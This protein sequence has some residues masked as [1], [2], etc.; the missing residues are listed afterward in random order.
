LL[1]LAADFETADALPYGETVSFG[2]RK[3]A[4]VVVYGQGTALNSSEGVPGES[5]FFCLGHC[6]R[7]RTQ[8]QGAEAKNSDNLFHNLSFLSFS[9]DSIFIIPIFT[10]IGH[11]SGEVILN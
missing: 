11:R 10:S 5:R 8:E 6:S 2:V 4:F 9:S 1:P 3:E 7:A